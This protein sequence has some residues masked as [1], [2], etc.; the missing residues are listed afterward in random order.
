M[1]RCAL[2]TGQKTLVH[3][4]NNS[5][6]LKFSGKYVKQCIIKSIFSLIRQIV[7]VCTGNRPEDFT[8]VSRGIKLI[9]PNLGFPE[10][11]CIYQNEEWRS[12]LYRPGLYVILHSSIWP[13]HFPYVIRR[14]ILQKVIEWAK[15]GLLFMCRDLTGTKF[16]IFNLKETSLE[17]FEV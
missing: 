2:G 8:R 10:L 6:V 9:N 7:E 12:I 4:R 17:S 1:L 11:E 3:L 16:G 14:K 15:S 5:N 13:M